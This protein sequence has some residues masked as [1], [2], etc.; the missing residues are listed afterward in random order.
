[1]AELW[2]R[3]VVFDLDG[4][5]IDS[6]GDI[7]DALNV[8]LDRAR[9]APFSQ[10]EVRLMVGGGARV[11]IER[12]LSARDAATNTVLAQSLHADFMEVYGA[13]SVARTVVYDHGRELLAEL[14]RLGI[15]RAICTNKPQQITEAVL[16][17]LELQT[18]FEAVIGASD[19][20]PKKPHPAMLRAALAPLEVAPEY[21]VMI[22]DSSADVGAARAAGIPVIAVSFGYT[23]IPVRELGA[24]F[25]IDSLADVLPALR[26]LTV[27]H[28]D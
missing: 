7:A 12:A 28:I 4:T 23:R 16:A 25:V 1:M 3:A 11:L 26:H 10:A 20:L 22:G 18:S 27:R 9:L 13:G 15:R 17:R 24:D 8:A 6:V 14:S 2:P 19:D 5:L 21:A